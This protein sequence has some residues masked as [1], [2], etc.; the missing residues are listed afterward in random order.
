MPEIQPVPLPPLGAEEISTAC[1]YCVVGC[2]YRVWRWKVGA[3]GTAN[4]AVPWA[5]PSQHN[6]VQWQ[7]EPHHVLVLPDPQA[8]AVNPLGN[9]SMRGGTLAQKCYNPENK[10]R[11]RLTT[12][13]LRVR[14]ELQPVSWDTAL[15]IMAAV[16]KHVL[17]NHGE[18]AWGVKAYSYQYFE[19]TYAIT[20]LALDAIG[21]PAFAPHDKCANG[22]DAAGLD[23]AGLEAFA[24]AYED[25]GAC[26]VLFMSGTDPF[27][28]KSTLFTSW[29]MRGGAPNKTL[30][31]A[32]PHRSMGVAWAEQRGGLWLPVI[33]GTD[34]LL[35]NA[36]ARVIVE[37]GWQ[38]Q[39]FIEH[40]VAKRW[41]V[42]QGY[43]RGTRNTPWQWRTTWGTWQSD[44]EDFRQFLMSRDE[45]RLEHAERITGVPATLIERA[46]EL[47]AKPHADGTRPKASFMLEKGNYWSN[48]YMNSAS[49]AA[50]GLVCGAGNRKGQMIGRGGGHQ[51]GMISAAGNPDWLS[52]EKYPGRRKKPLNLDRWL[53]DG[54]L[55]FA[56]VF[57]TTWIGAMAASDELERH[58]DRLTRGSPHQPQQAT[59]AAAA[60]A[61]IARADSG[62]MVLVDSD[63][64][65]VEP[66]GTCYAD[67]VLPAATWGEAD[68]TRCNGERRLRL[69][70]RFCDAPGQAQPDW[71]AVQ[72]FAR[73][74]GFGDKFAWKNG[75][76]V[77]EEA[78]RYSRGSPYDYFE[79]V[80]QARRERV[81]GHEYLRR[82]GGDGIQTPVWRQGEYHCRHGPPA[83]SPDPTG[84]TRRLPQQVAECLQH[85]QRQ[86]GAA[87][88][89]VEFSRLERVLRRRAAAARKAGAMDYQRPHQRSLAKR[90][91]RLAQ[92]LYRG[93]RPAANPVHESR[94]CPPARHRKRRPGAGQQRHG[95]RADRHAPGRHRTRDEFQWTAGRRPHP[96]HP[97]KFRGG[98]DARSR[99]ASRRRQ[100]RLQRPWQPCQRGEPCGPR[101]DDQ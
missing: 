17:K 60:A 3:G 48:N 77:F 35:H 1:D 87:Q 52:P 73:R 39:A 29:I 61:L 24:P 47:L 89:A 42:D 94:R 58:I 62:G 19:N 57:G 82:L 15:D 88:D 31:F 97:G 14:G 26:D 32:T 21:T 71:W 16:S 30:I 9:H 56:W 40:W 79:L 70:G 45:H 95:V 74:M 76:A 20:R 54:Q 25:W 34:T 7:G 69:Y 55:R 96:G 43:G 101:S 6:I 99:H 4:T 23:D 84:R 64:Y 12:P 33:P 5:N 72:A 46:A 75:N 50:L 86:G 78:A 98:G 65:P 83:R 91:R 67:I 59:V 11:E 92:T 37:R 68:F 8:R 81:T 80:E 85:P 53:M 10:T 44:W 2:S 49:F 90:L 100:S 66:L 38:D 41:E 22:N 93:A 51:R 28:T 18:H 13:L 36:I 63:I 27:E